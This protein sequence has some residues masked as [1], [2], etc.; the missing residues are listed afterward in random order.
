MRK[1]SVAVSV[2]AATRRLAITTFGFTVATA[3]AVLAWAGLAAHL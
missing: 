2:N 1:T 3:M